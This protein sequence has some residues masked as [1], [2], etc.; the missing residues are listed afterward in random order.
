L[1]I[2]DNN[3]RTRDQDVFVVAAPDAAARQRRRR[4]VL[5]RCDREEEPI[6]E[7]MLLPNDKA[8][9]ITPACGLL[10]VPGQSNNSHNG[11]IIIVT[12]SPPL[13]RACDPT[14]FHGR[15]DLAPP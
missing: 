4:P 11:T 12:T 14:L 13:R 1:T 5:C 2:C 8:D 10:L 15:L 9:I 7:G 6:V 3:G